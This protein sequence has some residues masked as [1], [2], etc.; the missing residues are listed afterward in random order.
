MQKI[1]GKKQILSIRVE[2]ETRKTTG[3]K[4]RA[5]PLID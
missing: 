1:I 4:E 5:E 2:I 3:K